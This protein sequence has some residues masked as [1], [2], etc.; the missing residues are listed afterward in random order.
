MAVLTRGIGSHTILGS[1]L[2]DSV[3]EAFD[4]TARTLGIAQIPGGPHLEKLAR[5]GDAGAHRL[6]KPLSKTR[7]PWLQKSCDYS[8]SGLKTAVRSLCEKAIPA[9]ADKDAPEPD[10][11]RRARADIA[12]SFQRVAVEH[13]C[14]RAGRAAEWATE[15][16]PEIKS[17]VVAGGVA[18]NQQV[19]QGL[20][21][22]A[23]DA[24]LEMRCPPPRLCVDN[25]VMVAWAGVERLRLGL[26]EEPPS[27]A[28]ADHFVEIRPRWPL[29]GRDPRST[30]PM[31]PK[32]PKGQKRKAPP[33]PEAPAQKQQLQQEPEAP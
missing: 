19:R 16:E 4:K 10:E 18:A 9:L 25:G 27:A 2:D 7:D 21:E 17:L 29:G 15:Q 28:R 33:A 26:Y 1:T 20:K 3:G 23:E 5:E 22:V 6:P 14:E 8:F 31:V 24:D 32:P 30:G 11:R 13:L 12:A